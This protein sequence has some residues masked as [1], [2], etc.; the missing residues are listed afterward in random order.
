MK[1]NST[2]PQIK[3]LNKWMKELFDYNVVNE[4]L[5]RGLIVV[6]TFQMI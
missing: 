4:K 1:L 3:Q 6:K 5:N 2:D